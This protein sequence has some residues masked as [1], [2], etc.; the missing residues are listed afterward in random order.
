MGRFKEIDIENQELNDC[1]LR[2]DISNYLLV[3]ELITSWIN[4]NQAHTYS[5]VMNELDT[6]EKGMFFEE[7]VKI[8]KWDEF[9]RFSIKSEEKTNRRKNE[10]NDEQ[11]KVHRKTT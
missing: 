3:D 7:M 8:K 11:D 5:T 6:M 4:G 10:Y 9:R 1:D 2:K